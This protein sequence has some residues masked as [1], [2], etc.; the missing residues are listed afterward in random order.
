MIAALGFNYKTHIFVAGAQI[1][2]GAQRLAALNSL[3]PYLVTKENLLSVTELEPFKNFS[4]QLAVL[5]YISCTAADAFS[6]TDSGSQLSS[7]V[8][9]YRIYYGGG[10]MPT[11]RPNKRRLAAIF[12][13]NFTIRVE[14]L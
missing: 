6:I 13:K 14:S 5:D 4:S 3:Y 11:I 12:M 1:Y 9:G 10:K 7:L 8:S 2:G